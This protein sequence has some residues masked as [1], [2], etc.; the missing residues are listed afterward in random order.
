MTFASY[1]ALKLRHCTSVGVIILAAISGVFSIRSAAASSG[2]EPHFGDEM[3]TWVAN[4]AARSSDSLARADYRARL[5]NYFLRSLDG[6]HSRVSQATEELDRA[7][8]GIAAS[9]QGMPRDD[10]ASA[11]KRDQSAQDMMNRLTSARSQLDWAAYVVTKMKTVESYAEFTSEGLSQVGRATLISSIVEMGNTAAST[12]QGRYS[13][14]VSISTNEDGNVQGGSAQVNGDWI[15]AGLSLG[16]NF[17]WP[18]WVLQAFY[19][20]GKFLVAEKECSDRIEHQKERLKEAFRQLPSKL[21]QPNALY[22]IYKDIY[23]DR[24]KQFSADIGKL[25][26]TIE[27]LNSQWKELAAFNSLRSHQS[28]TVLTAQKVKELQQQYEAGAASN[29]FDSI[30]VA[31]TAESIGQV[32]FALTELEVRV[33]RSCAE[34]QGFRAHEDF[35]DSVT[36]AAAQI[37]AVQSVKS[38]AALSRLAQT[39]NEE[40][41]S[42]LSQKASYLQD[43]RGRGCGSIELL[44]PVVPSRSQ[45]SL[46]APF[47]LLQGQKRLAK[48]A[49]VQTSDSSAVGSSLYCLLSSSNG[50]NYSC[51]GGGT[52]YSSNFGENTGDSRTNILLNP[53]DGGYRRDVHSPSLDAATIR[54]NINARIQSLYARSSGVESALP[55]WN[56]KN[57]KFLAATSSHADDGIRS[58]RTDRAQFVLRNESALSS[59]RSAVDLFLQSPTDQASYGKLI[60]DLGGTDLSLPALPVDCIVPGFPEIVGITAHQRS[61]TG[62]PPGL[63]REII[64]EQRKADEA[65]APTSPSRALSRAETDLASR[66]AGSGTQKG[67]AIARSLIGDAA[68]L[69][70]NEGGLLGSPTLTTADSND[71]LGQVSKL[72]E[73]LPASSVLKRA[74]EFDL[75]VAVYNA[76]E[77]AASGALHPDARDYKERRMLLEYSQALAARSQQTF[78]G[79]DLQSGETLLKLAHFALEGVTRLTPGISLARDVY[80]AVSGRDM[81]SGEEL[82]NLERAAAVLGVVTV[83]FSEDVIGGLRVIGKIA[84]M[85]E[86]VEKAEKIVEAA[87]SIDSLAVE[88]S[89]HAL[90]RIAE[91]GISRDRLDDALDVGSRFWDRGEK[92]LVVFERDVAAGEARVAAA[93]DVDKMIVNT[94]YEE[95]RSDAELSKVLLQSGTERFIP[96]PHP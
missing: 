69:R 10:A 23:T 92:S 8:A 91:K 6:V 60:S 2:C 35:F 79:G 70:F 15:D 96:L 1:L 72:T 36:F 5:L 75:N 40:V 3:L 17:F 47:P 76:K 80:E 55:E 74:N 64:R 77:V 34:V 44:R 73:S 67:A 7:S 9:E 12:F 27:I 50:V 31:R 22:G 26:K 42:L 56:A 21:L 49:R 89:E 32:R 41:Q 11:V 66:F 57:E 29:I 13:V 24:L 19:D 18:I 63:D 83:G 43:L 82:S 16:G 94:V 33:L 93:V 51:G 65:L 88:Y 46:V 62:V 61:Y 54:A 39:A 84:G 52:P 68:S 45:I 71:R 20:L 25:E 86:S 28:S 4:D 95:M 14:Y 53:T 38:N 90:E 59:A 30:F 48:F 81:L 58:T 87:R 78:F 37:S 85:G